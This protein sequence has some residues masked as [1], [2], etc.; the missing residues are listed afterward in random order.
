MS[1]WNLR[2]TLFI[3]N[4]GFNAMLHDMKEA[5]E[6]NILRK[7]GSDNQIQFQLF[8]DVFHDDK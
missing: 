6:L 7:W 2:S 4:V 3:K 5:A 8:D 1:N